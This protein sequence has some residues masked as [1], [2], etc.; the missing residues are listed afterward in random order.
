MMKMTEREVNL[1]ALRHQETPWIPSPST[2]QDMCIPTVLEEG[3]RGYGI[4]T[5]WFGVKYLY[6]EDQPGPMPVESEPKITDIENWREQVKMPNLDDYDWEGWAARDTASWDRENKISN[7]ILINGNFESLHMFCGFEEALCNI[8]EDEEA[9]SD[10][11]GWIADYKVAVIE[12][13]AKYY[14]PDM[15]QFH[16]DYSNNAGLFMDIPRWQRIC[17]PHLKK[18]IDAV[19]GLEM[20]YKHHSCGKIHDLIPELVELGVDGL[21]PVQVQNNPVEVKKNFGDRLTI[22]GGFDNQNYLD[23]PQASLADIRDSIMKTIH[24]LQP[25]GGWIADC[26]FIDTL[27]DKNVREQLWLDCLDEYNGPQWE[28]Y[29][30]KNVKHTYAGGGVYNLAENA[31]KKNK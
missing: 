11:M 28:K 16:D 17:K 19:H 18:V 27:P 31:E 2:G 23:N 7:V 26:S 24:D 22:C 20:I 30:V 9:C 21:N 5:D 10:F 14:K 6:R 3:A 8:M 1:L 13:I 15:I 12:R 4:T 29:G 25:G